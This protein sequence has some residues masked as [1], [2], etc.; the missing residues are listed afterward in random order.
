MFNKLICLFL[1]HKYHRTRVLPDNVIDLKCTRCSSQFEF[2]FLTEKKK[3]LTKK[4]ISEH[5]QKAIDF[6]ANS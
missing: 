2:N 3:R 4:E 5:T 1:G 6:F